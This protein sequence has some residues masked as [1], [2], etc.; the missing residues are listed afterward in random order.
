MSEHTPDAAAP[1]EQP[2]KKNG[3]ASLLAT[4]GGVS[5]GI[6]IGVA[7]GLFVLGPRL[8]PASGA[9]SP[10]AGE[11]AHQEAE[12]PAEGE[13]APSATPSPIYLIENMVLNPA[14]SNGTRFLLLSVAIAAKDEAT[15]GLIKARDAEVRDHILRLFGSKSVD[16]VW[17]ASERDGLRKDVL[18]VLNG[19]FPGGAVRTVYFPQFVIQ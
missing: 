7:V 15:I 11:A 12:A 14:G 10:R 16:Q 19:L 13:H 6:A 8:A 2:N 5:A 1:P 18:A 4:V 9:P 3:M 17:A